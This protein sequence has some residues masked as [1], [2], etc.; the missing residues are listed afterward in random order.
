MTTV[1]RATA[2]SSSK[3]QPTVY[4]WVS[5]V[6]QRIDE[7]FLSKVKFGGSAR[8]CDNRILQSAL[9]Y[10]KIGILIVKLLQNSYSTSH[11]QHL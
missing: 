6:P 11:C 4:L 1:C 8:M 10:Y 5:F 9:K 7:Y 2:F 3:K